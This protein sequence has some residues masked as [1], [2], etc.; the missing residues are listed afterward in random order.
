MIFKSK[1]QFADDAI[2]AIKEANTRSYGTYSFENAMIGSIERFFAP[3][4]SD[5]KQIL[6]DLISNIRECLI[7]RQEP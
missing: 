2:D 6:K 5:F 7:R 1:G 4:K 3:E